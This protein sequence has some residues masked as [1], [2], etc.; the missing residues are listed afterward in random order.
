MDTQIVSPTVARPTLELDL[1]AD[2]ACPWSFLGK[3]SLE[4]AL[5]NLYGAPVRT[6]RWHGLPL[7][8]HMQTVAWRTHLASRLPKGIDVDFAHRSL[9]DAGRE[10]GIELDFSKLHHVR[11]TREA[12][13][14]VT[15]AARESRQ[16][17]V[18]DAIFSAFFER[19][20]DIADREVL[21]N[22]AVDCKL[23]PVIQSA[24]EDPSQGRDD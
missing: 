7:Q 22:V 20:R 16:S 5:T 14:L 8:P 11:D 15:L 21:A 17:D 12:H 2:L 18:V 6:L 23:E 4:R 13:R 1:I 3:R 10:L 19:G 24:F 9:V